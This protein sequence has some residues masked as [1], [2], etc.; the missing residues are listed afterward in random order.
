M[1]HS[2][3]SRLSTQSSAP[4]DES[5]EQL[6]ILTFAKHPLQGGFFS[7]QAGGGAATALFGG[8][9]NSSAAGSATQ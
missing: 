3:D 6:T 7:A 4:A 5:L 2:C 1:A 8:R 9:L